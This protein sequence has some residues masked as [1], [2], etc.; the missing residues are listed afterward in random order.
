MSTP[1]EILGVSPTASADEIRKAY[2]KLAKRYHPDLNP[3]QPEAEQRFKEVTAAYDLLSDP[4]KRARF[5]RGEIDEQ[6]QDR[7]QHRYRGDYAGARH[8][9][10]ATVADDDLEHIFADLFGSRGFGGFAAGGRAGHDGMRGKGGNLALSLTLDFLDAARG[11]TRRV[12]LPDG[13]MLDIDLPAGIEDGGTVRLKGQGLPG[14]GGGPPGDALVTVQVRPHPWFRRNGDDVHM[15]LPV[16]LAEAVLGGKLRVPT[17][18]G[19]VMLTVPRGANNGTVLRL[20]GKGI[21]DP[22]AGSRGDQYVTLRITLPDQP[23]PALEAFVKGWSSAG[24]NPRRAMEGEPR[25]APA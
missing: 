7:P 25:A 22:H 4:D 12:T 8:P 16:T 5:D 3:G 14:I 19:P 18:D 1:Y 10:G 9:G 23:D 11:G 24:Y 2:R 13:R 6:G 17:I 15:D 20:K 21:R